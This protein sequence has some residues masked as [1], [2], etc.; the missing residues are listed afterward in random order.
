M[1]WSGLLLLANIFLTLWL[2]TAKVEVLLCDFPK[3]SHG[4]LYD[5]KK[6]DPLSPVLSGKVFCYSCEYN[7]VSPSNSFWTPITCSE[8]GWSPTPKCLN[9]TKTCGPPPPIDN[10]DITSF[11]LP[12]Y[13][14]LSS[15]EYQCQS[16]YQLQGNKTITCRNGEWSEPPKCL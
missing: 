6:Y 10:G 15:V 7:F 16:L 13:A 3:I 14:P 4:L 12:V 9:S 1:G 11:P 8:T 2:S 5:E